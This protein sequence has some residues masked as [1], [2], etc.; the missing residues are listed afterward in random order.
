MNIICLL[1]KFFQN[2]AFRSLLILSLFNCVAYAY[3]PSSKM[4]IDKVAENALKAPLYIEQQVHIS[5]GST[6]MYLKEQ[7]LIENENS[8]KLI[9]KGD[10]ELSEQIF[11]QNN[12]SENQKT[13][14]ISG[15]TQVVRLKH[16]LF[17]KGFFIKNA[18]NFKRYLIQEGIVNNE[19]YQSEN[20]KKLP[21]NSGYQFQPESNT[22]LGRIGGKV[23]YIIGESP[24]GTTPSPGIWIEQDLFHILKLRNSSGSEFRVDKLTTF[25]KGARW[26]KSI[27][28]QW[29]QPVARAQVSVVSAKLADANLRQIFQKKSDIRTTEFDRHI[30]KYLVE[31]FYQKFR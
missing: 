17:E 10:K 9:V 2:K 11:F 1:I 14:T 22:R 27:E 7:W 4:M 26:Y 16:P 28:M 5:S 6:N 24:N 3:I 23:A 18:E 13:T 21:G 25:S 20:F 12:Y 15:A 31:D 19:I 8:I 29:G 30:G